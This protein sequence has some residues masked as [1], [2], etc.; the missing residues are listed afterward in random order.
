VDAGIGSGTIKLQNTGLHSGNADVYAW[1]FVDP[2]DGLRETDIRAVGAQ[3]LAGAFGGLPDDDRLIGFA[4]NTYGRWT[5]AANNEVDV[6]VDTNRDGT[7]DFVVIAAD[8]GLVLAGS[9]NGQVLG[10]VV[11]LTTGD[12]VDLWTVSG[13]TNG[14]T[15]VVYAAASD[16]GLT[17][18]SG[19]FDY[20]VDTFSLEGFGDDETSGFAGFDPFQPAVSQGDFIGLDHGDHATLPVSVDLAHFGPA[21]AL[22][23]MI[24]TMDDANGGRQADLVSVADV[25]SKI[26]VHGHH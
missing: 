20:A 21:P 23:W 11:D 10:I 14:S 18:A 22:G 12:V 5:D 6:L 19:P 17:A 24:V 25:G 13:P 3:S 16:F 8:S 4:V 9:P 26:H 15:I 2:N 1:S 7:P